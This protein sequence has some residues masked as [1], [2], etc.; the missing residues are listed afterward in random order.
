MTQGVLIWTL[1]TKWF[2]GRFC[3]PPP[4]SLYTRETG[5]IWQ[6]HVL[7]AEQSVF[8]TKQCSFSVISHYVLS[9]KPR[10]VFVRKRAI[11]GKIRV[12]SA[13][14]LSSA[15]VRTLLPHKCRIHPALSP[16]PPLLRSARFRRNLL[17]GPVRDTP[18]YR[19]IPFRDSIAEGVSHPFAL[20]S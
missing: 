4:P 13:I 10:P 6:I 16:P 2:L 3:L 1:Q 18:P 20:F 11:C 9:D 5:T 15:R 14:C 8:A 17:S 7:T 12:L 19:A